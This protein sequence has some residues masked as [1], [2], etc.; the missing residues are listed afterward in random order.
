MNKG[1]ACVAAILLAAFGAAVTVGKPA[2][3]SAAAAREQSAFADVLQYIDRAWDALTRSMDACT[4]TDPKMP[5]KWVLYV[6]AEYVASDRLQALESRCKV[7]VLSLPRQMT[8]PGEFDVGLLQA[9]RLALP[10][11]Q[12]CPA[13]RHVQRNV[14]LDSCF[15]LRGLLRV[16]K[17]QLARGMRAGKFFKGRIVVG[18]DLMR[19]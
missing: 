5:E 2:Q 1:R 16:G 4:V 17:L 9:S 11:E 19:F 8:R 6:P 14:R 15:I 12:L 13:R 18:R 10:G 3:C 7:H